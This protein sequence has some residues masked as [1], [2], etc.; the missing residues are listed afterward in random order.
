MILEK[1][2][3]LIL[4]F[5]IGCL[6]RRKGIIHKQD[7]HV[8][9]KLLVYVVVPA[10]IIETFSNIVIEKRLLLLPLA[11]FILLS[12]LLGSSFLLAKLLRL[13]EK[14]KAAFITCFPTLEGGSIG[15]SFMLAA[16]GTLGLSRIVLFD[17][18]NIFFIFVIS[19]VL[20]SMLGKRN[21]SIRAREVIIQLLKTPIIW[22]PLI[23]ILLNI[24]GVHIEL[25]KNTLTTAGSGLLL[26]VMILLGIEFEPSFSSFK[27]PLITIAFK[28]VLG[29]SIGFLLTIL[30]GFTGVERIAVIVA[31]ALP[32][33][34]ITLVFATEND[35]DV[36]Y[37][38]NML[39]LGLVFSILFTTVL[40]SL[41]Q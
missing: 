20:A 4:L 41:L 15:Y 7:A 32:A 17:L 9:S 23:G 11:S 29:V 30:F 27:L 18:S 35:L 13:P 36:K 25:L 6:L 10:I 1:T 33:S 3:P 14:T 26:L 22:A 12:L 19:Y 31:S 28:T 34:I 16:F 39:S 24:A 21:G 37:T 5:L 2:I 38:A 40:I 8:I